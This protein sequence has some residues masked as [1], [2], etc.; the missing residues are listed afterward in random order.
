M[1]VVVPDPA[2]R[3]WRRGED[4]AAG[5]QDTSDLADQSHRVGHVL[6]HILEHDAVEALLVEGEWLVTVHEQNLAPARAC[7]LDRF[8]G[9]V[10]ARVV[11]EVI[12]DPCASTAH[13]EQSGV[14]G[15][16]AR[17]VP[18]VARLVMPVDVAHPARDRSI[19]VVAHLLVNA[20]FLDPGGSGGTE[21]YL[22]GLAPALH[23]AV[24]DTRITVATTRSGARSLRGDG[25][26]SWAEIRTFP[27]EEYQRGRRQLCEQ[28]L[29]PAFALRI[30][31]DLIHSLASVG[32]IRTP[33]TPH[34]ITL[35]DVTFFR[36]STFNGVTTFG[37]RQVMARAA[38]HADALIAVTQAARD[39]IAHELDLDSTRFSIVYHG[40][41]LPARPPAAPERD[42][43]ARLRLGDRRVILCLAAKRPHK[44]QELLVR[45]ASQLPDDIVVV[46]AGQP[47]PYDA[48]LRSLARELGVDGSVVFADYVPDA[49]LEA[50]WGMAGCAAFPTRAEGFGM[51][52]LEAFARGVPV[53][54]S[55]LAVLREIGGELPRFFDPDDPADAA[56]K[57]AEALT[58]PHPLPGAREWAASFSWDAAAAATWRAYERAVGA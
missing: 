32:P 30:G 14:L 1:G 25:W 41:T 5:P 4:T 44:N 46:L 11:V 15:E 28:L 50:L 12:P 36:E 17:H 6:E 23:R 27:C 33:G 16:M 20:L 29:L 43:R 42:V 31:A 21:T 18:P 49:E 35:H 52:I 56:R 55:D 51:P 54:C 39:D 26:D 13:V 8:G 10:D 3:V 9:H 57:V 19:V 53:A 47:E 38:R 22:R 7:Q 48:E 37:M 58:L 34:V 40:A 45:A 24:P 2:L